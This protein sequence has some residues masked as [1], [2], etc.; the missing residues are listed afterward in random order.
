MNYT[1]IR[2]LD[3]YIGIP[4]CFILY[5]YKKLIGFFFRDV[6][7]SPIKKILIIKLW[8]I[9]TIILCSPALRSL[10]EKYPNAKITF[11]TL[12]NNKGVYE[13]SPLIDELIYFEIKKLYKIPFDFLKLVSKLRKEKFDLVIDFE[14]FARFSTILTYLIGGK[15]TVGYRTKK[16]M[17]GMV[18]DIKVDYKDKQYIVNTFL[19]LIKKI[20]IKIKNKEIVKLT[21]PEKDKDFINK[22]LIENIKKEYLKIGI[23]VNASDFGAARRWPHRNFAKIADWIINKYKANVIFIGGPNDT[24][25]VNKTI[26][27]M[28]N[29]P[30]NIAGKTTI[31]QL[32]ALIDKMDLFI[33]NDTGPLHIAVAMDVPT[34]SF[35]GPETPVIYGPKDK[36]KH[37]IF[38]KNLNCSPCI[39][40][41]N[42][43]RINCKKNAICIT[44]IKV[45]EVMNAIEKSLG[46]K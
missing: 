45:E 11:V 12:T 1:L 32:I 9:G 36:N 20:G 22:F 43:K 34:I 33:T 23:N 13:G 16:Q 37:I 2:L 6:N 46:K 24:N 30:I 35:F 19:D 44:S 42:A 10:K 7:N 25:L 21:I 3:K 14:L 38:Y 18:Y 8:G 17:R 5:G 27:L 4:L 31:K 39:R 15:K 29:K 26:K 40:V 28:K 41:Y